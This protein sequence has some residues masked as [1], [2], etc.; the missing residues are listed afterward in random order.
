MDQK[1]LEWYQL[2][3]SGDKDKGC[4]KNKPFLLRM[5]VPKELKI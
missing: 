4:F 5:C 2:L 1:D 3:T